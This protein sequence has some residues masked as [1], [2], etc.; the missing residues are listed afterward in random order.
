MVLQLC[1]LLSSPTLIFRLRAQPQRASS[2]RRPLRLHP[3][4]LQSQ[5]VLVTSIIVQCC[6]F[7]PFTCS[8]EKRATTLILWISLSSTS[9]VLTP[10]FVVAA[11]PTNCSLENLQP[12]TGI[13]SLMDGEAGRHLPRPNLGAQWVIPTELS[14]LPRLHLNV[15]FTIHTYHSLYSLSFI[16]HSTGSLLPSPQPRPQWVLYEDYSSTADHASS[17]IRLLSRTFRLST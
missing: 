2:R 8:G 12:P 6:L 17:K 4:L 11:P 16:E 1:S 10:F 3:N 7:Y 14:F 5:W 15:L 13:R 9:Q